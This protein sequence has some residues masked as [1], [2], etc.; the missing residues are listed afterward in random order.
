MK[1]NR[2]L[3]PPPRKGK[4][5]YVKYTKP[6]P[7]EPFETIEMDIKFIYIRGERNNALLLTFL[8][9]FTRLPL[10][11]SL[12]YSIQHQKV[13]ELLDT[14]IETWLQPY[15]PPSAE[16]DKVIVTLRCDNDSRFVARKLQSY[17]KSNFIHQEFILPATPQQNAHIE[18]FHRVVEDLVC[19][20]YEFE[21]IH[22]AR[23]VLT[24]FYH[25]YT[26]RRTISSILYL[27]PA[28]FFD[29]WLKGNIGVMNKKKGNTI[30][31]TFFFRGQ[32]PQW[33]SALAEELF[34]GVY[35]KIK[36]KNAI[37]V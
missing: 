31:Q 2:L 22:H 13:A 17:L 24:R 35:N 14:V 29:E 5:E 15:R 27:P 18:S 11:W 7:S 28:I 3:F 37:F 32:R 16:K 36:T 8:D 20:K 12:Q 34:N 9:T 25:T 33:P 26:Y 30:K 1:E 23:E 21:N 19:K 10:A 6:L 4:R